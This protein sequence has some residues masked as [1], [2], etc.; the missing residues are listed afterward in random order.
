MRSRVSFSYVDKYQTSYQAYADTVFFEHSYEHPRIY[1]DKVKYTYIGNSLWTYVHHDLGTSYIHNS[2]YNESVVMYENEYDRYKYVIGDV[3]NNEK[4][5][6]YVLYTPND[7]KIQTQENIYTYVNVPTNSYTYFPNVIDGL[8]GREYKIYKYAY[9]VSTYN[10]IADG[11]LL[12]FFDDNSYGSHI[13]T[14]DMDITYHIRGTYLYT[15]ESMTTS[16][17]ILGVG[18]GLGTGDQS[19]M[20]GVPYTNVLNIKIYGVDNTKLNAPAKHIVDLSTDNIYTEQYLKVEFPGIDYNII[21]I[22]RTNSE[23]KVS[24]KANNAQI[25]TVLAK[26]SFDWRNNKFTLYHQFNFANIIDKINKIKNVYYN[27]NGNSDLHTVLL[28]GDY[29]NYTYLSTDPERAN[30]TIT[31]KL[32]TD[33]T[34]SYL[35]SSYTGTATKHNNSNAFYPYKVNKH[36]KRHVTHNGEEYY[37]QMP[38]SATYNGN[39][40]GNNRNNNIYND[41]TLIYKFVPNA[42][43]IK[44]TYTDEDDNVNEFSFN[45]KNSVSL[46]F[47][48]GKRTISAE[49]NIAYSSRSH[50]YVEELKRNISNNTNIFDVI[51]NYTADESNFI[52]KPFVSASSIYHMYYRS[53]INPPYT[54]YEFK[55]N[56]TDPGRYVFTYRSQNGNVLHESV[57]NDTLLREFKYYEREVLDDIT[58]VSYEGAT[59]CQLLSPSIT[60]S[61]VTLDDS[62]MLITVKDNNNDNHAL[63]VPNFDFDNWSYTFAYLDTNKQKNKCNIGLVYDKRCIYDFNG[64]G[65][66]N[67]SDLTDVLLNYVIGNFDKIPGYPNIDWVQRTCDFNGDNEVDVTDASAFITFQLDGVRNITPIISNDSVN[68]LSLTFGNKNNVYRLIS[69]NY[70]I[71]IHKI[72]VNTDIVINYGNNE[73]TVYSVGQYLN[74]VSSPTTIW[75]DSSTKCF[76]ISNARYGSTD[77]FNIKITTTLG[78]YPHDYDVANPNIKKNFSLDL[79]T[80]SSLWLDN[81]ETPAL[82]PGFSNVHTEITEGINPKIITTFKIKRSEWFNNDNTEKYHLTDYNIKLNRKPVGQYTAEYW[83]AMGFKDAI[84]KYKIKFENSKKQLDAISIPDNIILFTNVSNNDSSHSIIYKYLLAENIP[85]IDLIE[86]INTTIIN[87]SNDSDLTITHEIINNNAYLVFKPSYNS[88]INKTITFEAQAEINLN[89]KKQFN[90]KLISINMDPAI[91]ELHYIKDILSKSSESSESDND[92]IL[93]EELL[94]SANSNGNVGYHDNTWFNKF[95]GELISGNNLLSGYMFDDTGVILNINSNDNNITNTPDGIKLTFNLNN[96]IYYKNERVLLP[97]SISNVKYTLTNEYA[98]ND[99]RIIFTNDISMTE[100]SVDNDKKLFTN[101]K[102]N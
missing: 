33:K 51:C 16:L 90:V 18:F 13:G 55:Y 37:N 50:H 96:M 95:C 69:S 19:L 66:V 99:N 10:M 87:G 48:E 59:D 11:T 25:G 53:D 73:S 22:K 62:L 7:S 5:T 28:E 31:L 67:E 45:S 79:L 3:T 63:I 42:E 46:D 101:G 47:N 9:G 102:R 98:S 52:N 49:F 58:L 71:Q 61:Y 68:N 94:L 72:R 81:S 1:K 14:N 64:D 29:I 88:N 43:S 78:V 82:Y 83:E 8:T 97:T 41:N 80:E 77:E 65:V 100:L 89:N 85:S 56:V 92:R 35:D 74:P 91:T 84:A 27:V 6:S 21:N 38:I 23:V 76:D 30:N 12:D 36:V 4:T 93:Y 2:G 60:N 75:D 86:K 40:K 34:T 26:I 20:A 54:S 17:R 32:D 70:Y 44:F 15:N 24:I 57:T 39:N